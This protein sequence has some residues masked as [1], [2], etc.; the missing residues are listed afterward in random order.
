VDQVYLFLFARL[1]D[2]VRSFF[3]KRRVDICRRASLL[4]GLWRVVS[5]MLLVIFKGAVPKG[6]L[7]DLFPKVQYGRTVYVCTPFHVLT[8][9]FVFV[10]VS[11]CSLLI[12]F[13]H[14]FLTRCFDVIFSF[15]LSCYFHFLSLGGAFL[16]FVCYLPTRPLC[17]PFIYA[18]L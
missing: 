14:I 2:V 1:V 15:T 4:H 8:F 11:S 5:W 13:G 10:F 3:F 16:L 6:H 18:I 17:F 7:C 12:L 9:F